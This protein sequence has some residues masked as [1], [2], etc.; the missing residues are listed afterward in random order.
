MRMLPSWNWSKLDVECLAPDTSARLPY[1]A[2]AQKSRPE[3]RL[4]YFRYLRTMPQ[5]TEGQ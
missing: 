5:Q 2:Q 1:L 4:L 3:R